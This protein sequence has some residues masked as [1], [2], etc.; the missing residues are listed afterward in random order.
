MPS[1]IG[2]NK[3]QISAKPAM[4]PRRD[5]RVV[6]LGVML[7]INM[8]QAVTAQDLPVDD[9]L[10]M[11]QIIDKIY[12]NNIDVFDLTNPKENKL[13]FRLANTIHINTKTE[14]IRQFLLFAP[15][16]LLVMR[17]LNESERILRNQSFIKDATIVPMNIRPDKVDINITTQDTWTLA[18]GANYSREG[19]ENSSG[20]SL[21]E[22][23]FLGYGKELGLNRSK[24]SERKELT[25]KYADKNLFG[26]RHEL[27]LGYSNNSDGRSAN[28]GYSKPFFSF[29]SAR[30]YGLQYNIDSKIENIFDRNNTPYKIERHDYFYEGFFGFAYLMT[31]TRSVRLTFGYTYDKQLFNGEE[32]IN[33]VQPLTDDVE[34]YIWLGSEYLEDRF[35]KMQRI[36]FINN[37]EDIN[38]GHSAHTRIGWSDMGLGASQDAAILSGDYNYNAIV[39]KGRLFSNSLQLNIRYENQT[40]LNSKANM[41]MRFYHRI[42]EYVTNYLKIGMDVGRNLSVDDLFEL[43]GGSGL[44]GY[45]LKLQ[46]GDKRALMTIEQRYYTDWHLLQLAHVGAVIFMDLGRA[47]TPGDPYAGNLGIM[48]DL[49]FGLRLVSSRSSKDLVGHLDV[50]FPLDGDERVGGYQWLVT[51]SNKF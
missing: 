31:D 33:T 2:P 47:W 24:D 29:E 12:I 19:G 6:G 41:D 5:L 3:N 21:Q 37:V 48:K 43:G 42:S 26:S 44:R 23:N 4:H 46:R 13:L 39:G 40:L 15:G 34:S 8:T 16:E 7:M 35:I 32:S 25:F 36:N 38:L 20:V 18:G 11:Q 50:S 28:V 45:P 14:V 22:S 51:S 27:S 17:K 10:P 30:S 49:G 9:V 1:V